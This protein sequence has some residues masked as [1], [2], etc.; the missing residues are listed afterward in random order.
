MNNIILQHYTGTLDEISTLSTKN[1]QDYSKRIGVEWKLVE[2]SVFRK[3]L[4]NPCQ[5]MFILDESLDC[6]DNV[7]MLDAD[8]FVTTLTTENVF[9]VEPGI[10]YHGEN[11]IKLRKLLIERFSTL[12]SLKSPYWS[13]AFYKM[14]LETRKR[15]R[16]C[17]PMIES[18]LSNSQRNNNVNPF[19]FEDEGIMHV[20]ATLSGFNS[21]TN[22]IDPRWCQ[23]SYLPNPDSAYMLHIR[24]RRFAYGPKIDK[25]IV[26]QEFLDRGIIQGN[27][28]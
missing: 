20:L 28:P 8:V 23:C 1:V 12:A 16:S 11:Q 17:I 6:Y 27:I 10:G 3:N 15:L 5:K 18:E 13:G 22:Y 4:S 19:S 2:G 24:P 14:D 7:L 9:D 21:K 26:L 25:M